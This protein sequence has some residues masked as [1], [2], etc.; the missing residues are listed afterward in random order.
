MNKHYDGRRG[1]S[2][3]PS[4]MPRADQAISSEPVYSPKHG[5][6]IPDEPWRNRSGSN[7]DLGNVS[8]VSGGLCISDEPS[9]V[10]GNSRLHR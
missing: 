7:L 3:E 10:R 1:I 5:P 8:G 2:D 6:N 9:G 4:F